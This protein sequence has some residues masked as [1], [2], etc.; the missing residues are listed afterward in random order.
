MKINVKILPSG[1]GYY[2]E[3][4]K[5]K[6]SFYFQK[7]FAGFIVILFLCNCSPKEFKGIVVKSN[8]PDSTSLNYVVLDQIFKG[9]SY[10]LNKE[11]KENKSK[12][13][14]PYTLN[15]EDNRLNF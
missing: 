5:I 13:H 15:M 11:I 4:I 7:L 3:R 9:N 14:F 1:S 2:K 8:L 12:V 10:I 6:F